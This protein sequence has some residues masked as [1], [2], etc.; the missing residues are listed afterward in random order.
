MHRHLARRHRQQ[1]ARHQRRHRARAEPGHRAALRAA[2]RAARRLRPR[3]RRVLGRRS[4][5]RRRRPAL[6]RPRQ[7]GLRRSARQRIASA[8]PGPV[9]DRLEWDVKLYLALNG[10]VHDAAIT[11]WGLKRKYDSVRPITMIRYMGGLGQSSDPNGPSYHPQGLPLQPG[12][13]EVDHRRDDRA[14]A[15]ATRSW[16]GTRARSRSSPGPASPRSR[17]RRPA[18][19]AGSAPS[20]GCRTRRSTFVTPAFPG[21][22]LATAP[23]AAPRPRC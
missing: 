19:C 17:R 10:A 8:A 3:A 15:S 1:P 2:G 21:S 16:P 6:E 18:A 7:R 9:L 14:R 20:S 4:R 12:V 23:S 13:I 5:R 11:A 22:R